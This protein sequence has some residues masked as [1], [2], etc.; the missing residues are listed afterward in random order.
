MTKRRRLI[1]MFAHPGLYQ[2]LML[3]ISLSC[4]Q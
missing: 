3:S 1:M 4:M 2:Q